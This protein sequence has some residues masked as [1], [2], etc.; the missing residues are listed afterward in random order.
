M[1]YKTCFFIAKSL[2]KKYP[3]ISYNIPKN[4]TFKKYSLR[5]TQSRSNKLLEC[6]I[7]RM[8]KFMTYSRILVSGAKNLLK[9][10]GTIILPFIYVFKVYCKIGCKSVST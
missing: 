9:A 6:R 8:N 3:L 2:A 7:F 10:F 4:L 5:S 1:E